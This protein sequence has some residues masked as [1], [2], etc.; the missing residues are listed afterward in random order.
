MKAWDTTD[1][2]KLQFALNFLECFEREGQ[3]DAYGVARWSD[4]H[5]I[6]G[7]QV[8]LL[9]ACGLDVLEGACE[10]ARR[11]E[12]GDAYAACHRS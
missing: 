11:E 1:E 3:I 8:R 6:Q 5:V 2:T 4:G 9:A 10:L 7:W 12:L